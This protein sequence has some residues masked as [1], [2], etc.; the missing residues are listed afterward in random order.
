MDESPLFMASKPDD[1]HSAHANELDSVS[2]APITPSSNHHA[3]DHLAPH[4][5]AS[6]D[7]ISHP[8]A[9]LPP[10]PLS[11]PPP[12]TSPSLAEV[13][14]LPSAPASRH[15]L[16]SMWQRLSLQTKVVSV[17]VATSTIPVLMLGLSLYVMDSSPSITTLLNMGTS[18]ATPFQL[19]W[20]PLWGAVGAAGLGSLI[21]AYWV[22]RILQPIVDSV[23]VIQTI[24]DGNL[25]ARMSV[26]GT[27][28]LANLGQSINQLTDQIQYLLQE[29]EKQTQQLQTMNEELEGRV[30]QRTSQLSRVINQLKQEIGERKQ[31][32]R[33]LQ[34]SQVKLIHS[35]KMSG[36]GQMVAGIA[37]EINNPVNFIHGNLKHVQ[38]HVQEILSVLE[39]YQMLYP[40]PTPELQAIAD[41]VDIEF[42][43]KD[44]RKI[45]SSMQIGTNRILD[46]VRSLRTFSRMDQVTFKP[47]DIH[48]GIESTLLILKHR[49][50]AHPG[51]PQVVVIKQY[52]DRLPLVDCHA[53]QINQVLMNILANAL[54]ALDESGDLCSRKGEPPMIIISTQQIDPNHIAIQLSDNGPGIPTE[55]QQRL[56]DPFFT[57]KPVGKGTGLGMSISYTII[58]ENHGGRLQLVSTSGQG[59]SFLI[60]LPIKQNQN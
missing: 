37:H 7:P 9:S 32:E 45:V 31:A 6:S 12:E 39:G 20:L 26:Q 58:T 43:S 48:E 49:L 27:D 15:G 13:T 11:S 50:K 1:S 40:E 19:A 55:V 35:E 24:S 42:L 41:D 30:Q 46:I 57:T 21:S 29:R 16:G 5:Q 52:G 33:A 59:A 18:G 56:F 53:G 23:S 17:V 10:S 8:Q 44:V 22:K 14:S 51:R 4:Q 47:V 25:D 54:D 38:N 34:Q 60:E 3:S 28:E 36:L 2:P